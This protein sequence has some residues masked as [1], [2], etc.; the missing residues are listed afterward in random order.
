MGI[1]KQ[2]R[3][4]ARLQ[5]GL[6]KLSARPHHWRQHLHNALK[7]EKVRQGVHRT[8]TIIFW[9]LIFCK[10]QNLKISITR[11]N[12]DSDSALFRFREY[13]SYS[14]LRVQVI[15]FHTGQSLRDGPFSCLASVNALTST[16]HISLW[17]LP[18]L[19]Q[20]YMGSTVTAHCSQ[21]LYGFSLL[22]GVSII[23]TLPKL[24]SLPLLASLLWC[25]KEVQTFILAKDEEPSSNDSC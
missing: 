15:V 9:S 12:M 5:I 25:S 7:M 18:V 1:P 21:D 16:E 22:P 3:L 20:L 23:S 19:T 4:W 10:E 13:R 11:W 2:P 24:F 14:I 17:S 6:H 8:F